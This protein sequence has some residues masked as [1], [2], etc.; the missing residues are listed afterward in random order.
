MQLIFEEEKKKKEIKVAGSHPLCNLTV[1]TKGL[2]GILLK[3]LYSDSE[4]P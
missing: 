3:R 1:S 4:Q 2:T